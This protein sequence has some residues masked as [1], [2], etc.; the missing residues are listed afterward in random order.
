MIIK[1]PENTDYI[2]LK[3]IA[4]LKKNDFPILIDA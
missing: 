4:R 3:L 2:E 1:S